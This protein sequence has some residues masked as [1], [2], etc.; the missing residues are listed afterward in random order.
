ML[1]VGLTGGIGSGK[2]TV[3]AMIKDLGVPIIDADIVSREVLL[4]YPGINELIKNNFGEHFFDEKGNLIRRK[5][6]DFIFKYPEE[7]RKLEGLI[8]PAIKKEIFLRLQEYDKKGTKICIVDAPTLIEQGLN[9]VM[10]YNI[11]VWVDRNTQK[12]RL[13][14]RD[15]LEEEQVVNRINAQMPLDDKKEYVNF[16]IDNT[17]DLTYTKKQVED[18]ITILKELGE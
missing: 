4:I 18:I 12:E 1:K 14:K 13:K 7:R 3:S 8:I 2:S 11:L 17:S 10:D 15:K 16:I 9:E 5:L 6:G